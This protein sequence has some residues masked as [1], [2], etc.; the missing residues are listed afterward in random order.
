MREH[1]ALRAAGAARGVENRERLVF[2]DARADGTGWRCEQPRVAGLRIAGFGIA[3][4]DVETGKLRDDVGE[5]RQRVAAGDQQ[6]RPAVFDHVLEL[7]AAQQR[8]CG[9]EDRAEPTGGERHLEHFGTVLQIDD[10]TVAAAEAAT[11]ERACETFARSAQ[12]LVGDALIAV[13]QCIAPRM[14]RGGRIEHL[15]E[16]RH[17]IP[18]FRAWT[19]WCHISKNNTHHSLPPVRLP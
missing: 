5:S 15:V 14:E 4:H 11:R 17:P 12:R 10:D 3:D 9:H 2:A 18:G 19:S 1:D 8:I 6:A 13:R 7:S 16:Q